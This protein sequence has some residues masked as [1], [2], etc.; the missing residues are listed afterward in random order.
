MAD[1]GDRSEGPAVRPGSRTKVSFSLVL[2]QNR[3]PE[4]TAEVLRLRATSAVSRDPSVRLRMTILWEFDETSY[5]LA[6]NGTTQKL[7]R[8]PS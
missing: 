5:K 8:P 7:K 1:Q 6:L 3:H 4:R 2:P